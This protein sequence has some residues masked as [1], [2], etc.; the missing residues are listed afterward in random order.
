M[1]I[2][3]KLIY[4]SSD[5][6]ASPLADNGR[7]DEK[8]IQAN[9]AFADDLEKGHGPTS[10]RGSSE[11]HGHPKRH[12]VVRVEVHDTGIGLRPRDLQQ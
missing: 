10:R 6:Q 4:P 8:D 2:T 9:G 5:D 7:L 12:A 3:T 1:K 11:R